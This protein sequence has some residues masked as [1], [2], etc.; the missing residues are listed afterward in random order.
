MSIEVTGKVSRNE[1]KIWYTFEWGKGPA[2][3]IPF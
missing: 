1:K 2:E 3:G